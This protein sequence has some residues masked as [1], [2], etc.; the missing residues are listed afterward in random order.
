MNGSP[1]RYTNYHQRASKSLFLLCHHH[2]NLQEQACRLLLP[3]TQSN[4]RCLIVH[5]SSEYTN[6]HLLV[7][8]KRYLFFRPHRNRQIPEYYFYQE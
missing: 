2:H 4:I 1:V 3:M 8:K 6:D 5:H 7:A